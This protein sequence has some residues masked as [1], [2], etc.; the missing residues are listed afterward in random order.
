MSTPATATT[1]RSS[2]VVEAPIERAFRVF[3]EDFGRFKPPEHNMLGVEIA[4]PCS[5]PAQAVGFM[6]AAPTGPSA[7]G[8]GCSHTNRPTVS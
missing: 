3:T 8:Q 6:T 5:S 7:T 2:I 1:A 4:E